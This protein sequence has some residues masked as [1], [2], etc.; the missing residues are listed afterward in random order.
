MIDLKTVADSLRSL[1]Q[2]LDKLAKEKENLDV[3]SSI[4]DED[5]TSRIQTL[6]SILRRLLDGDY[7][8]LQESDQKKWEKETNS[9]KKPVDE[10]LKWMKDRTPSFFNCWT[11]KS[12]SEELDDLLQSVKSGLDNFNQFLNNTLKTKEHTLNQENNQI[13]RN[14]QGPG[15]ELVTHNTGKVTQ[16]LHFAQISIS[17]LV[18]KHIIKLF[19]ILFE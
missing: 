4:T 6:K 9:V 15:Q 12:Q 10:A 13:D 17:L 11:S 2:K 18:G 14:I 8:G 1:V 16:I 3:K 5:I 19:L 7:D